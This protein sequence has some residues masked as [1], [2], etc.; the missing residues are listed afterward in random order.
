[1]LYMTLYFFR[2]LNLFYQVRDLMRRRFKVN[3]LKLLKFT[4]QKMKK[5]LMENLIFCAVKLLMLI[6][7]ANFS[8]L[9]LVRRFCK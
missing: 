2:K 7:D 6:F 3:L 8:Y 4:A 1:M 5:P 9:Y